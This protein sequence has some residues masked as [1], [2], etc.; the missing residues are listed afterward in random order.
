[1][2]TTTRTRFAPSPTGVL[3]LGGA[4]TALFCY[5]FAKKHGGEFLL[6]IEDTD[7]ERSR[8]EYEAEILDALSW[9]SLEWDALYR[10]SDRTEVYKDAIHKLIEDDAAYISKEEPKKE[11]ERSEVIRFRNPN[12]TISFTDTI[13]GEVT[14]DTTDLGD[15]VIARSKEE[16][17]YHLT[18]VVDDNAMEISHVIRAEEHISNTPRQILIMEALGFTRPTYAHIPLL[19][20]P[21]RSKLSKRHGA[22]SVTEYKE[23]GFISDALVNYLALLGW[24]PGTDQEIFTRPELIDAFSLES[25]QKGGAVFEE[26]KLRW[27]NKEH[28]SHIPEEERFAEFYDRL[29]HSQRVKDRGWELNKDLVQRIWNILEE[30]ISVYSDID[31]FLADGELDLY[32]EKPEYEAKN[33]VWKDADGTET[34]QHLETV[35]EKLNTRNEEEFRDKEII[36]ETVWEYASEHGRGNVLWPM[37]YA[38]SGKD[39]SPDPFMLAEALGKEETLERLRAAY[40]KARQEFGQ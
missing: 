33:L 4:R 18:V 24:N 6:R 38:L 31:S 2:P 20:A 21:D 11:G 29:I 35:L 5:L 27:I 12:T 3:H 13:R 9:L 34:I 17:L 39:K 19:L 30:R 36:K 40:D 15:F 26:E 28:L 10:Q 37:R 14:F 7:K 32:F 23:K 16:P 22:V 1:M 8:P 25:V